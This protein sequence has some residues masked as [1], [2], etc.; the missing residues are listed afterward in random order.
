MLVAASAS[1]AAALVT[2][3]VAPAPRPRPQLRSSGHPR[4][5]HR[6]RSK[7][8]AAAVEVLAGTGNL[9]LTA[10]L[11]NGKSAGARTQISVQWQDP[12][13]K[14]DAVVVVLILVRNQQAGP[15]AIRAVLG[16]PCRCPCRCPC[17]TEVASEGML[18]VPKQHVAKVG[19]AMLVAALAVAPP[20]ATE[21]VS[22]DMA[23]MV[24]VTVDGP[25]GY[26]GK[27]SAASQWPLLLG[28]VQRAEKRKRC[29]R[30]QTASCTRLAACPRALLAS[31]Q[32]TSTKA[33]HSPAR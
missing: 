5:L 32:A 6:N 21:G 27:T 18:C 8:A 11:A 15:A 25:K 14:E 4:S 9:A 3:P 22:V 28:S 30:T 17:H 10:I 29:L 19:V 13:P 33:T 7:Y 20:V 2:G 16:H 24:V 1:V 31:R 12:L 26:A 23:M